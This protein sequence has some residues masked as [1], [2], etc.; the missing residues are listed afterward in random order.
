MKKSLVL[1]AMAGV[2]LAGCV[3]DVADVQQQGQ[4]AKISFDSPVMYGNVDSRA[5]VFGE[6]GEKDGYTY[7]KAEDFQIYAVMH[8]NAF[9]GWK[10]ATSAAFDDTSISYDKDV[11]GWAPKDASGDYY[12]WEA[13][14]M[15][16]IAASSPAVLDVDGCDRTYGADGL[17]ISDFAVNA[18]P[19]KQYDLLFSTRVVNQK[20]ANMQHGTEYY[21]G[22]PILFQHALSSVRFSLR[23]TSQAVVKLTGISL[24]G[25]KYKGDFKEN[26]AEDATD[27]TKYDRATNVTPA[28]TVDNELIASP[29]VAFTGDLQFPSETQYIYRLVE[30]TTGNTESQLLLMPQDLTEN[31][32]V[33]VNYTVN[34][35]ANSKDVCLKGLMSTKFAQN[36]D[37]ETETAI[38]SWEIGKRYTYRLFYSDATA[39]KDRIFF[40]PSTEGWNDVDVIVVPL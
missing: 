5:N 27:Y 35:K 32:I 19:N 30:G 28:W 13:G 1:M 2:A 11:D 21:S 3:N 20:A 33:T 37:V 24:S 31:S 34:G 23:N 36:G 40:A 8:E 22:I 4:K 6:I 7:P 14:K 12:Y 29:Y 38:E 10:N 17:T 16:S 18:D 25:V 15:L 39:K 26:L 9:A